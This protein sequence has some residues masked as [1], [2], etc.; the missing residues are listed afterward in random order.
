MPQK[1]LRFTGINR[2]SNEFNSQ[3]T[4]EE[5]VNLRP[6]VS[7]FSVVKPKKELPSM[8]SYSF[9]YEHSF[10]ATN[11]II[12]VTKNGNV[13]VVGD[14]ENTIM[15]I[16][17]ED[18]VS[19][20]SSGNVVLIYCENNKKQYALK[21][22][23]GK[24]EPYD[25]I[26]KQI[27]GVNVNY[28]Y[29]AD[30]ENYV[31]NGI[32][33]EGSVDERAT[34]D[35]INASM[36]SA[37][38]ALNSKYPSAVCGPIVVGFSYVL[39]DGSEIASTAFT[40]VNPYRVLGD[41]LRPF[42]DSSKRTLY[43]NAVNGVSVTLFFD[44]EKSIG[45]KHINVYASRQIPIY[46]SKYIEGS[47]VSIW[48]KN[49]LE[50][51]NLEGQLMYYQGKIDI[52]DIKDSRADF[53]L[54]FFSTY[55]SE[56]IMD[57]T[58]GCIRRYGEV[59][60]Y[61]NRF[62]FFNSEVTHLIQVPTVA[63]QSDSL[64]EDSEQWIPYVEINGKLIRIKTS[65]WIKPY[66]END[67]IYPLSGVKKLVFFRAENGIVQYDLMF[68]VS[69]K[70]SSS[71]N[72][73]YAFDVIPIPTDVPDE[74]FHKIEASGQHN[75]QPLT[76]EVFLKDEYN[77]INVSAQYNPFVFDVKHSYAFSGNVLDVETAYTPISATQIGQYPISVFT[78]NG[79]FALEQGS[80]TSLYGNI[81]P[82]QPL[83]ID[84]KSK[85]TPYGTFFI[86]SKNLY[87]LNGREAI[88]VSDMMRGKLDMEIRNA[89]GYSS[90]IYGDES[91]F[92]ELLSDIDFESFIAH[93]V[94]TYDPLQ[95]ELII[96]SDYRY[97]EL[98][99]G[100]NYSYVFN[101][102]TKAFHKI[103]GQFLPSQNGAKYVLEY[104]NGNTKLLNL[105][106]EIETNPV[107]VMLQSRPFSYEAFYTHI[108]RLIMLTDANLSNG[109][110]LAISV[111]GSDNLHDWRCIIS[112]QK[113]NTVLRQIRTNRAAKSY[114]DYV[115]LITGHV[116]T[117]TDISDIIA[118]YSVVNRKL[119]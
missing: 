58:S 25:I 20:S 91:Y 60:S 52:D 23:E 110:T 70:D 50:E 67:F 87:L 89:R 101:F 17:N 61:N 79:I 83:V 62:H 111:F 112:A 21:Y 33:V 97:E 78:T 1:V 41:L 44:S 99:K 95:N 93:A 53:E 106:E 116:D 56:A 36:S 32:Y 72:Y 39:E 115:I 63:Y 19:F 71:Y 77:A 100:Q 113:K 31:V 29:D 13:V 96:S 40:V 66:E 108:N 30:I 73:S 6:E 34:S 3:G 90:L 54:T 80:G 35:A 2:K 119:G 105:T 42:F 14:D 74:L 28:K 45:V 37:I 59:V 98:G 27:N 114:R 84:G 11:N 15:T 68:E 92:G 47:T 5:L 51:I 102:N 4:C 7:G 88:S 10:G 107:K 48:V 57:V 81:I 86:S 22:N 65:Y 49:P 9:I 55:A 118:D 103:A 69:L 109:R 82:I 38:S 18:V 117:N 16:E 104:N 43:L 24:Y 8:G 75:D 85:A 12:A 46:N 94:L 26:L 76:K 64:E